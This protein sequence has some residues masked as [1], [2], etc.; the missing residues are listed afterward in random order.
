MIRPSFALR[1]VHKDVLLALQ[2]GREVGV[3]MRICNL[4]SQEITEAMN[5]G[6]GQRDSSSFMVLQQERSG[7]P[8]I[9]VPIE[10]I[11]A[12]IKED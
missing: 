8:P 11:Q 9:E 10:K 1:L 6:W 4:V 5:R 3:P 2:L 12:A 7:I